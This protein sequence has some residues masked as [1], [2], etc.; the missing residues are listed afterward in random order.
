VAEEELEMPAKSGRQYRWLQA[1]AHGSAN[2]AS[3]MSREKAREWIQHTP[4]E[5]RKIFARKEKSRK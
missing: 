3:G 2:T 5:K 4:P 1:V